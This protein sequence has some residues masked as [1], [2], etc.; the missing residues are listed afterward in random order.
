MEVRRYDRDEGAVRLAVTQ[1]SGLPQEHEFDTIDRAHAFQR[2]LEAELLASGWSYNEYWPD[3]RVG[4]DRRL[5]YRPDD[6]RHIG[7]R[8]PRSKSIDP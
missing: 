3:R 8:R 6:R 4:R 2:Q 7:V 5:A 1:T